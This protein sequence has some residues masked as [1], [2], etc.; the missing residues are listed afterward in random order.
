MLVDREVETSCPNAKVSWTTPT[1]TDNSGG[2]VTL[3]PDRFSG[4]FFDVG[5]TVVTYTARDSSGNEARSSF[6]VRVVRGID[7]YAL[8]PISLSMSRKEK[9]K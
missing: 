9:E 7:A 5:E 4:T 6:V 8:F 3:E 2:E 1:V